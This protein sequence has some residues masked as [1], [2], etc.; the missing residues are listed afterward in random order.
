MT[1]MM[2]KM[3]AAAL[4][5]AALLASAQARADDVSP[6]YVGGSIGVNSS[7]STTCY[8]IDGC[9]D[10]T[11][12]SGK[13]YGGYTLNTRTAWGS[14]KVTDSVEL[15]TFW[16]NGQFA[17]ANAG[18]TQYRKKTTG[19]SLSWAT[20]M[21]LGSGFA[22]NSRIGLAFTR[23]RG[24]ARDSLYGDSQSSGDDRIAPTVGLGLSYAL[25]RNWSLRADYDYVPIK[26][27]IG[28]KGNGHVN[29]WSVGAAYHF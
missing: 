22:L 6:G 10:K 3:C 24:E 27:G 1:A 17:S 29:M 18:M 8:N 4:A 14:H 11:N 9:N 28:S 12:S 26:T 5:G 2:K 25:N 7:Y 21:E 15:S 16:I 19:L 13:L 20:E 23:T